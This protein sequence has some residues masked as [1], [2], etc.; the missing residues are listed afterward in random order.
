MNI[1]NWIP[2]SSAQIAAISY[3]VLN[4]NTNVVGVKKVL[5]IELL[6]LVCIGTTW[7]ATTVVEDI[8]RAKMMLC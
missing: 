1:W 2:L 5:K 8:Y 7:M 3:T 6:E 4:N